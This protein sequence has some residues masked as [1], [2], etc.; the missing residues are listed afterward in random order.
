VSE[1]FSKT[2]MSERNIQEEYLK[3]AQVQIATSADI[4]L[5]QK[6]KI[7]ELSKL[8]IA[9]SKDAHSQVKEALTNLG[10]LGESAK[11]YLAESEY[12]IEGEI[13]RL[14][15]LA[16]D[17]DSNYFTFE[18]TTQEGDTVLIKYQKPELHLEYLESATAHDN[19][20]VMVDGDISEQ[21]QKALETLYEKAS[22]YIEDNFNTM[23]FNGENFFVDKFSLDSFDS[24]VLSGFEINMKE[25]SNTA[26]YRYQIDNEPQT[27]TLE[28]NM[29]LGGIRLNYDFS[30]TTDLYQ[31]KDAE[32][33]AKNLEQLN[34][35][36][37]ESNGNKVGHSG[38]NNYFLD[39]YSELFTNNED[40]DDETTKELNERA[41]IIKSANDQLFDFET[42]VPLTSLKKFNSLADHQFNLSV[43]NHTAA[44]SYKTDIDMS[45][46]TNVEWLHQSKHLT[47]AKQL[48]VESRV[49]SYVPNSLDSRTHS[50]DYHWEQLLTADFNERDELSNYSVFSNE[51]IMHK[52]IKKEGDE[53]LTKSNFKENTEYLDLKALENVIKITKA[54]SNLEENTV[55]LKI[56][57]DPAI[58][59]SK[60][61][62]VS[63]YLA[64]QS[65]KQ[66]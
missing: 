65:Y 64:V 37:S 9:T 53:L 66:V 42:K 17:K 44:K 63:N 18:V 28:T 6:N 61:K 16:M 33:L 2:D 15:T 39:N 45:Q 46:E 4:F 59:L 31:T 35:I 38:L 22:I 24:S 34:Q 57:D 21:E 60:D 56:K 27:K 1:H 3:S 25:N 41:N 52:N 49:T 19:L 55:T 26:S 29:N 30:L 62:K 12:Y 10:Q 51:S 11:S 23:A 54:A 5:Q 40:P 7:A 8:F 43:N 14:H 36:L 20:F 58:T 50:K 32:A 47:Q 13:N 48:D